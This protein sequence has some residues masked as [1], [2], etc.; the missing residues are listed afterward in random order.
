MADNVTRLPTAPESYFTIRKA[1]GGWQVVLAT[2]VTGKTL[3]TALLWAADR[4][5]A[6]A[7][8]RAIA[9]QRQHPFKAGGR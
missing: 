8:G 9:A 2:P 4:E 1:R 5:T 6:I 7:E 3:R